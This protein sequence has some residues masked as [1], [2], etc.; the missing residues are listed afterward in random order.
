[1]ITKHS[2]Q[3]HVKVVRYKIHSF[4]IF[5]EIQL[6]RLSKFNFS[7]VSITV[8]KIKRAINFDSPETVNNLHIYRWRIDEKTN[9]NV[10]NIKTDL[11]ADDLNYMKF[12]RFDVTYSELKGSI[13][14]LK[15]VSLVL[16]ISWTDQVVDRIV[17]S[18][19]PIQTIATSFG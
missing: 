7:I 6:H 14:K 3:L 1:M 17:F 18:S 15:R 8:Y 13:R 2:L 19:S 11:T 9:K 16:Q 5:V 4:E 12:N 10:N